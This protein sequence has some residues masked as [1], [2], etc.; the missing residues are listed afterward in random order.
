VFY[1]EVP[2]WQVR[3]THGVLRARHDRH[4]ASIA[5]WRALSS[6]QPREPKRGQQLGQGPLQKD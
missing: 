4:C 6:G 1:H 2:G 3:T 5:A